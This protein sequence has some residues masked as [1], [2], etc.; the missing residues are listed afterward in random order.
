MTDAPLTVRDLDQIP[1]TRLKGVGDKKATALET[2][3]VTS[4]LDLLTYYP[5]RYVDR[6]REARVSDLRPGEEATV[7]VTV[8]SVNK[9]MTRNRKAMVTAVVGDGSGR[10]DRLGLALDLEVTRDLD[11]VTRPLDRVRGEPDLGCSL[12]V[13]ELR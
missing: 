9:R 4:V 10:L 11:L 1:V 6:T 2:I 8:R 3:G 12:G 7:L 5:R 13:E